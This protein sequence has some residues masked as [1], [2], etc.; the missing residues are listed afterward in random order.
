MFGLIM[1]AL[2][3]AG[4]FSFIMCYVEDD[5]PVLIYVIV[6]SMLLSFCGWLGCVVEQEA[7]RGFIAQYKAAKYTI[8]ASLENENLTDLTRLELLNTALDY[9]TSLAI[10]QYNAKQWHGF[11]ISDEV[12]DLE[13]IDLN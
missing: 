4:L 13:P 6:G 8:E 1:G 2:I 5:L 3:G 11:N 7:S 9:N 10:E 12:L